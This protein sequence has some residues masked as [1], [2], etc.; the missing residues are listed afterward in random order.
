MF[1]ID[2]TLLLLN[3]QTP[4]HELP[5]KTTHSLDFVVHRL[6]HRSL[7]Y[8][9]LLERNIF[10]SPGIQKIQYYINVNLHSRDKNEFWVKTIFSILV[11]EEGGRRGGQKKETRGEGG[12][13]EGRRGE[14]N[15]GRERLG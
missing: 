4:T 13:E 2:L 14:R 1:T 10:W 8:S 3:I 6:I 9:V 7:S 15:E 11:M 12:R 5:Q